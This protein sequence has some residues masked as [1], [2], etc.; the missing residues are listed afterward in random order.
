MDLSI[1]DIDRFSIK[2]P[3]REI[4]AR[5]M[6]RELPWWDHF[7]I[8]QVTLHGGTVGYGETMSYYTWKATDDDAVKRAWGENAAHSQTRMTGKPPTM[9]DSDDR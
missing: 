5:N 8:C 9:R 6:I 1:I 3:F 4:T 2:V 7:E